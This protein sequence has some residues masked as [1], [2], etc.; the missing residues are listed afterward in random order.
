MFRTA[1]TK[2]NMRNKKCLK[3]VLRLVNFGLMISVSSSFKLFF[4]ISWLPLSLLCLRQRQTCVYGS[5][6][7][8]ALT[9]RCW[10]FA[11]SFF[12]KVCHL[13]LI[14]YV[15]L[16]CELL[17]ITVIGFLSY[18]WLNK[19]FN[20]MLLHYAPHTNEGLQVAF[21]RCV[22]KYSNQHSCV[23]VQVHMYVYKLTHTSIHTINYLSH[24]FFGL[25]AYS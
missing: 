4:F 8:R 2:F 14:K 1:I 13:F 12:N 21:C 20:L 23:Y 9:G 6:T 3:L 25:T 18:R 11:G 5:L 19:Y 10:A 17:V 15:C 22:F 7:Q 16:F 24:P